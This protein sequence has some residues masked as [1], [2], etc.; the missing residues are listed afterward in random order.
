MSVDEQKRI[1]NVV[2][3]DYFNW[4]YQKSSYFYSKEHEDSYNLELQSK[5]I[6]GYQFTHNIYDPSEGVKSTYFNHFAALLKHFKLNQYVLRRMK[7]NM[8]LPLMSKAK[9]QAGIPHVDLPGMENYLTGIYYATDSDGDTILF[10]RK[11]INDES[12]KDSDFW[13]IGIVKRITPKRGRL[14]VFD[15]TRLH[16]G[17]WPSTDTPRIVFN[18]NMQNIS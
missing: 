17:N 8:T 12:E 5:Y 4:F 15:G 2:L 7:I 6:D 10:D 1:Q 14:V 11:T 9:E 13:N 3:H 16:A 18:I